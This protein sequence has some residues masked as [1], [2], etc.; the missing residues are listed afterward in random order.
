MTAFS[1]HSIRLVL[2]FVNIFTCISNFRSNFFSFNRNVFIDDYFH[3]TCSHLRNSYNN[4][5][6]IKKTFPLQNTLNRLYSSLLRW[7]TRRWCKPRWIN[8]VNT[9]SFRTSWSRRIT[10]WFLSRLGWYSIFNCL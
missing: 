2:Y 9:G 6:E 3:R 10:Q 7:S 8:C 4:R 1:S 5:L